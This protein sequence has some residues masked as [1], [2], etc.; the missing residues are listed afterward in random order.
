MAQSS[1]HILPV[2]PNSET[3]NLRKIE[4]KHVNSELTPTNFSWVEK[5]IVKTRNELTAIVKEKKNRKIQSKA[6]PIRE[7][8]FLF[9]EE[10]TNEEIL[11]VVKNVE[12]EFGIRAFQLH[13]HRDEGH[14]RRK[15][16][17]GTH[18]AWKPNLHA[19]VLFE[20][21]DRNTGE[22]FK[23]GKEDMSRLQTY[24]ADGLNMERGVLSDKKHLSALEFKIEKLEEQKAN[25]TSQNENLK[26]ELKNALV[27]KDFMYDQKEELQA[28]YLTISKKNQKEISVGISLSQNIDD[29]EKKAAV[30]EKRIE[31]AEVALHL[32]VIYPSEKKELQVYRELKANYP[33]LKKIAENR[34][35]ELKNDFKKGRGL[36]R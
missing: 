13:I 35:M 34:E 16:I 3:H 8:V 11:E 29:L 1:I 36:S 9:K 5:S 31:T 28:G 32:K 7:G 2:K 10:N 30:L 12:K 14:H 4:Y 33:E 18:A 15:K 22:S 19:H 27:K 6:T 23:L 24:F 26:Q 17:E 20:W 21:I 25:L